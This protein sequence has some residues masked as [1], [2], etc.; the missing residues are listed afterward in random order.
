MKYD[1]IIVAKS[2]SKDLIQVTQNCINSARADGADMNVIVV[3]TSGCVVKYD[4]VDQVV[5]YEG[6]FIYNRALN[7]GLKYAEGDIHIL[8]NNDLIFLPGWSK[9][10]DIMIAN[11]LD[12]ASALSEDPRQKYLLRGEYIY[13]YN[14]IGKFLTGWCIFVT[15]ECIKKIGSLDESFNFWYSDNVYG[16]QLIKAGL[17]HGLVCNVQVNHITSATL[18]TVPLKLRK[19]YSY[20]NV[21]MYKIIKKIKYA[22]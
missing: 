7:L 3:E 17:T 15:R 13:P 12:S 16:D 19:Q 2:S 20:D 14:E 8:A 6:D 5:S 1:L 4:G 11:N 18:M 21:L 22:G 9:I 10:G